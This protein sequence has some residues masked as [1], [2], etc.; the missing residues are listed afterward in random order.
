MKVYAY[1]QV[2]L[3]PKRCFHLVVH[4]IAEYFRSM[5]R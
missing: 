3:L 5:I 4:S 1:L 2:V